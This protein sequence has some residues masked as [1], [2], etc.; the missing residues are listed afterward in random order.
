MSPRAEGRKGGQRYA[1]SMS[2]S[3]NMYPSTAPT[4]VEMPRPIMALTKFIMAPLA[5]AGK[6]TTLGKAARVF[7]T[8]L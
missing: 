5:K 7:L 1:S 2:C 3:Q 6:V 4:T 8:H